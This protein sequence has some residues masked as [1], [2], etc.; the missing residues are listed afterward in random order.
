MVTFYIRLGEVGGAKYTAIRSSTS[1]SMDSLLVN[2]LGILCTPMKLWH[3]L[4]CYGGSLCLK[5]NYMLCVYVCVC[6]CY[7]VQR[8]IVL[9]FVT[10]NN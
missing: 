9:I 1:L 4:L 2:S 10:F 7:Y 3:F 8:K 6:V 5:N